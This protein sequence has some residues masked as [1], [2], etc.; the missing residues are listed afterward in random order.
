MKEILVSR[1]VI[2]LDEAKL[3]LDYYLLSEQ[4][5]LSQEMMLCESFGAK[6]AAR[7]GECEY[8]RAILNITASGTR[9][10]GLLDM[11]SKCTVTPVTLGEVVDDWMAV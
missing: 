9:I 5:E 11:L 10:N 4:V 8:S 6:I 7:R 2:E 3:E 1:K